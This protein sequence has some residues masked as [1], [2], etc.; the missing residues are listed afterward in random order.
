V[1]SPEAAQDFVENHDHSTRMWGYDQAESYS[2]MLES[3][4]L[5]LTEDTFAYRTIT[6]FP[7]A[8]CVFVK[9]PTARHGHN[10]VFEKSEQKIYILRILHSSM[11]IEDKL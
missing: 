4:I 7:N 5:G 3:A 10:I 8:K 11:T 2:D 6:G 9:W 1:L